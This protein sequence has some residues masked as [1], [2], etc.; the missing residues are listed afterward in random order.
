MAADQH[1][2]KQGSVKS[3]RHALL[4]EDGLNAAQRVIV[5]LVA[6]STDRAKEL[7][8]AATWVE[9]LRRLGGQPAAHGRRSESRG[10]SDETE[11]AGLWARFSRGASS[12]L[13]SIGLGDK[14]R[15][16]EAG[17]ADTRKAPDDGRSPDREQIRRLRV[18]ATAMLAPFIVSEQQGF[19]KPAPRRPGV[20]V[21]ASAVV[22]ALLLLALLH[23]GLAATA[24]WPALP[25]GG[26]G[27]RPPKP[28]V[29]PWTRCAEETSAASSTGGGPVG[30]YTGERAAR[31]AQAVALGCRP[32]VVATVEEDGR[33][34]AIGIEVD[35]HL[36]GKQTWEGSLP[37]G[38]YTIS[39]V[40]RK[41]HCAERTLVT[42]RPD[43]DVVG[44]RLS[45]IRPWH[46]EWAKLP[47]A[48]FVM[49]SRRGPKNERPSHD[50]Q[51]A[52]FEMQQS[53]VTLGL[54]SACV[55]AGAC[56]HIESIDGLTC[57][58]TRGEVNPL[59]PVSCLTWDQAQAFARWF[60]EGARLCSE[61]EWE[62]AARAAGKAGRRYP[63]GKR[64]ASCRRAVMASRKGAG[65]GTPG[66]RPVCGRAAGH[67]PQGVCDL[68]GNVEEWTADG[69][70]DGY[71]GAPS[72][73]RAWG[74]DGPGRKVV[75][76][77]S[78]ASRARELGSTRRR[79]EWPDVRSDRIG[80]RLCRDA[81]A[82]PVEPAPD[83][84]SKDEPPTPTP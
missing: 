1:G 50:V 29:P 36:A 9:I 26:D 39:A 43:S 14:G 68:L 31:K 49:G 8:P 6:D 37:P 52:G 11:G 34:A 22:G 23:L 3:G 4:S 25:R 56:A 35:G 67:S 63:W 71:E 21:L 60:G 81:P 66:P 47:S 15:S 57:T 72:D 2:G 27:S 10:G 69:Y 74:N 7:A 33:P 82:P 42:V 62:Y 61:A 12:L 44:V 30:W 83:A 24:S 73:G 18:E 46:P 80:M 84:G 70:H 40:D 20:V 16:E 41:S 58:A 19:T 13:R 78:W 79:G 28:T 55:S 64:A 51:V 45:V 38:E 65:C 5:S 75:R 53:E 54:Y 48:E 32:V 76:G 77:G 59:E 17:Q